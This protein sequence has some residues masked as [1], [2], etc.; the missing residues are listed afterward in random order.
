MTKQGLT[1]TLSPE[2][3]DHPVLRV[4]GDLD[5]HTSPRL[6][7]AL[8]SVTFKPGGGVV[9]DL[10]GLAYCD[11]TGVTVLVAG[12]R[13]AQA[14]ESRILFAGLNPDLLQMFRILGLDQAFSFYP[15]SDAAVEALRRP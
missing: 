7:E 6:R 5:F 12:Y 9:L 11:S 3:S 1:V 10:S 15:D 4:A 13:R 8:E 2:G 14:A